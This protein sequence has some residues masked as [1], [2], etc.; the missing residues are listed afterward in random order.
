MAD[1]TIRHTRA[2]GTLLEGSRKGDGVWEILKS[3][4]GNWRYFRSIGQIGLGQSR[5]N[6][7]NTHRIGQAAE[8]LRAAGHTVTVEIDDT[9][10]RTMAEQETDRA[11][12][13]EQRAEGLAGAAVRRDQQA[14]AD[15]NRAHQMADAIPFGQPMMPD[16]HSYGRDVNYRNKIHNTFGRAFAGM[17]EAKDLTRRAEAAEANQSHRESIPATLRRIEKLEADARRVQRTIDGRMDWVDDG[18]GGHKLALVKPTGSYLARLQVHAADLAEK[19]THWRDH[20]KAAEASGV[21]VWGPAD[22]TKGDFVHG[23]WGWAEVLRVNP[24]SVT[25]PWGSNAVHL[26]VVTRDNVTTAIGGPGWTDKVTY[27]DVKGR[28]S[29]EEMAAHIAAASQPETTEATG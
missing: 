5:D 17:D 6:F 9:V 7:A 20:V 2:D 18:Q 4:H 26:P 13:A 25:I 3:L 11:A 21:K 29:A 14:T 1:I 28:K 12:R 22:F 27:D 23:R 16:H 8:A 10:S 19:I 24:K 15:Y